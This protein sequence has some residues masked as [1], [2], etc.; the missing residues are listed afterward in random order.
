[1]ASTNSGDGMPQTM[2]ETSVLLQWVQGGPGL[3]TSDG[4]EQV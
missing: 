3:I 4:K 1:M 2:G